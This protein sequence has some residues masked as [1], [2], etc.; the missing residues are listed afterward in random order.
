MQDRSLHDALLSLTTPH[1]ADAC[2]RVGVPIR[3]APPGLGPLAPG[4]KCAG[5]VRPV[6]HSGSVDIFLE[7]L[8]DAAAGDVLVI[9]NEGRRDEGCIGDLVTL[10][11][12]QAGLAGI[13]LWGTHRDTAE[14]VEIG[15]PLFSLGTMPSGPVRADRRPAEALASAK[16]GNWVVTSDDIVLADADGAIFLPAAELPRIVEA[17]TAIR[18]TEHRHSEA[19]RAGTSFREQTRFKDYLAAR[20]DNP[21]LDFRQHLRRIGG[22]IE[23]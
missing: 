7:A 11:V 16:I 10:E 13:V 1:L 23:E 18:A 14:I 21:A 9:D 5:R 20:R 19:M 6:R 2:L 4:M 3:C 22:S 8:E 17:G 15:L 12:K